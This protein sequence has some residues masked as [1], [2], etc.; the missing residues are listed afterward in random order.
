MSSRQWLLR[1]QDGE[2]KS[3]LAPNIQDDELIEE[4]SDEEDWN[5]IPDEPNLQNLPYELQTKICS[6][7]EPEDLARLSQT[8][9]RLNVAAT[10][11]NVWRDKAKELGVAEDDENATVRNI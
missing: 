11:Q 7:L 6:Y 5:Y 4:V 1:S 8:C 2:Y 9:W 3:L 10:D